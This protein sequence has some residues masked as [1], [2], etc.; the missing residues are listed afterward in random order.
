MHYFPI[1]A[2]LAVF[3]PLLIG[4]ALVEIVLKGFALWHAA[5]GSQKA[6]FII[7]LIINTAGILPLIYLIWFRP[8]D[9]QDTPAAPA[10]ES[11]PQA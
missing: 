9:T 7:M 10:S 3:L 5:R 2:A 11:S 6:W 4:I 8:K 1:P